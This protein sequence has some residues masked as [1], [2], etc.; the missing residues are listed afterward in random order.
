MSLCWNWKLHTWFRIL[1]SVWLVRIWRKGKERRTGM[2][3]RLLG[4]LQ[5]TKS[6]EK[7]FPSSMAGIYFLE[8][9]KEGILVGPWSTEMSF[10]VVPICNRWTI[11]VYGPKVWDW[12]VTSGDSSSLCVCVCV[13][14]CVFQ[15]V[16]FL[17]SMKIRGN[18]NNFK[19]KK[20]TT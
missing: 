13:C 8:R 6:V 15:F 9:E 7:F 10:W 1:Q 18:E 17:C 16:E 14:V 11:C 12:K 19:R 4:F 20:T 3:I 2:G 5:L